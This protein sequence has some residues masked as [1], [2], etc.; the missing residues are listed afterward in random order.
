[1]TH[2]L[3]KTD[4]DFGLRYEWSD[5]NN[6]RNE[7]RRPGDPAVNR[8]T[9]QRDQIHSDLFNRLPDVKYDLI[10]TNPPYKYAAEFIERALPSRRATVAAAS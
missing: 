2:T 8:Y 3:G 4:V 7:D 5:Q 9:T 1:M 10:V 6:T